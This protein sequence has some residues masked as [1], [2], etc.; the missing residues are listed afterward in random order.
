M[1]EHDL[2]FVLGII[3]GVFLATIVLALVC[4]RFVARLREYWKWLSSGNG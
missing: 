1:M 3:I 4:G 2:A